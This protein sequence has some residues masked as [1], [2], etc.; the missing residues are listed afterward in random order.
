VG[1]IVIDPPEG[2]MGEYLRQLAR[3]RDWPVTTL[4]PAHG[5]AIP[6]GPGKLQE[7]LD[8][9][10][11]REARIVEAVPAEGA[12]LAEVV[13][14]AYAETPPFLHPVAERSAL[15]VLLK[16]EQEGRLREDSGRYFRV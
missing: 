4:H 10:A 13:E 9:R 3:L 12:T 8:H 5:A 11:A 1:T 14:R 2:D 7:Y 16:L 6:D 15:A